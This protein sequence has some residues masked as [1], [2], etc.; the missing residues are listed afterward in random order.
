MAKVTMPLGSGT[1][2]GKL[3]DFMVF[4]GWKGIQCVRQFVIPS[5]PMT[6]DQGDQRV[7]MGG[8]GRAAKVVQ[9]AGYY[10]GEAR[11]LAV[12]GQTWIST[13]VS[14]IMKSIFPPPGTTAYEAIYTAYAAHAQKAAFDSNAATL[15]LVNFDVS[16]KATAHLFYAGMQLYMLAL[17]G[18]NKHAGD[19]SVFNKAPYTTALA[20]WSSANITSLVADLAP[21]P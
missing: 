16:Y 21:T 3:A 11:G 8:T 19:A 12:G 4:F 6:A 14:Y 20:S 7:M 2:S 15:G 9:D 5:N 17:Y 13:F 1:A 18:V 10:I